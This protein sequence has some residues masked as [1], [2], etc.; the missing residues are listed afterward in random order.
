LYRQ[1]VRGELLE[2]VPGALWTLDVIAQNRVAEPPARLKRVVVAVDPAVTSGDDADDTG[3]VI[4]AVDENLHGYVL[5]DWTCHLSPAGWAR[6]AVEAYRHFDADCIV[7]EVN[8]G[9]DLVEHAVR[10]VDHRVKY[11]SVRAS[12]G[13]ITRAEP[14]AALDEQG[15][16][17]H[18]GE[19]SQMENQM[20]EFIN[21][22]YVGEGS[23]DRV[24]ARVWAL[25]E[26]M[27]TDGAYRPPSTAE[28]I[29]RK[30]RRGN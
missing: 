12:R 23:P 5:D 11:K 13:K 18:V 22:G 20:L 6:R 10:S 3:I 8:N 9:G 29:A 7:G 25:T 2:D 14:I 27:L 4:A 1:E 28:L 16:I 19:F 24:D 26:L 30:R 17:H 21:T 15:K